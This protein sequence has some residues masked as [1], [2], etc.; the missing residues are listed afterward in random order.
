MRELRTKLYKLIKKKHETGVLPVPADNLHVEF[1]LERIP[2][3]TGEECTYTL[4][5][6]AYYILSFEGHYESVVISTFDLDAP[7]K[8]IK[9]LIDIFS[10]I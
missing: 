1:L 8:T 4:I 9:K 6:I 10:V 5:Y 3:L 2:W 7:A